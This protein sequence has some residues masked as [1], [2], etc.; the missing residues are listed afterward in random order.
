MRGYA[1]SVAQ[2]LCRVR[3]RVATE[4]ATGAA[5]ARRRRW[6]QEASLLPFWRSCRSMYFIMKKAGLLL[7]S[8]IGGRT[9]GA[10]PTVSHGR[11]ASR[12]DTRAVDL[13][14]CCFI[15]LPSI[16]RLP[17]CLIVSLAY[18]CSFPIHQIGLLIVHN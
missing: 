17:I 10:P 9:C 15:Y 4:M 11:A 8:S 14:F 1:Y 13:D 18:S 2:M 12:Q 7:A 3:H 5:T 6:L 16:Y